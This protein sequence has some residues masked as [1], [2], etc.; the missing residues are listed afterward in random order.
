MAL[1][2]PVNVKKYIGSICEV[3]NRFKVLIKYNG[4]QAKQI[5]DNYDDAFAWLKQKNIEFGLPIRNIIHDYRDYLTCSLTNGKEMKFDRVDLDKVEERVWCSNYDYASTNID[6]K[7][8]RF[9]NYIFNFQPT[10]RLSIDHINH[11]SLDNR[12]AN[13][14][15]ATSQ[16]QNLNKRMYS[17]NKSG[18]RGVH[19][20]NGAW[21]ASWYD[22]GG[23]VKKRMFSTVRHGYENALMQAI[24][25]REQ[26]ERHLPRY[27]EALQAN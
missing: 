14:R 25:C 4:Y 24:R 12:R 16:M 13:L 26:I 5:F 27:R 6:G 2:Y 1:I 8:V 7:L 17:N 3:D 15:E 19:F 10:T 18:C 22:D 11:D 21:I 20:Q 9:H 23:I